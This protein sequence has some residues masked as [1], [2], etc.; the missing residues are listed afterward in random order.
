MEEIGKLF[1]I[2]LQVAI[3]P[4]VY[5]QCNFAQ[6]RHTCAVMSFTFVSYY[7]YSDVFIFSLL[8]GVGIV[9]ALQDCIMW[10]YVHIK[11]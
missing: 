10:Y 6:K 8:A 3:V 1:L 4:L 5:N 11:V 9:L 7:L 2:P